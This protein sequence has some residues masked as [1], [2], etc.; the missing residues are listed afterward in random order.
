MTIRQR[1]AIPYNSGPL[2]SIR[3]TPLGMS[4]GTI[5]RCDCSEQL[6]LFQNNSSQPIELPT[7][8]GPTWMTVSWRSPHPSHEPQDESPIVRQVSTLKLSLPPRKAVL[9]RV[10][11]HHFRP[12]SRES[13]I[14][15]HGEQG[16]LV[17]T[18]QEAWVPNLIAVGLLGLVFLGFSFGPSPLSSAA[19]LGALAGSILFLSPKLYLKSSRMFGLAPPCEDAFT[20]DTDASVSTTLTTRFLL[21]LVIGILATFLTWPMLLGIFAVASR[22]TPILWFAGAMSVLA[23]VDFWL[24]RHDVGIF[25]FA[26][27]RLAGRQSPS[28]TSA[29]S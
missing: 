14:S 25:C 26:K 19:V 16:I 12:P 24:S 11:L 20:G 8:F 17:A 3:D 4:T 6:V 23:G 13:F 9:A 18:H 21:C 2:N 27:K 29:P 10:R 22:L 28:Q 15:I 5:Y 7:D 1:T